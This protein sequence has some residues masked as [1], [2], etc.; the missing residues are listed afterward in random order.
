M[1]P[2]PIFVV[3]NRVFNS[4]SYNLKSST[5]LQ[6]S[7]ELRVR[8]APGKPMNEGSIRYQT[9]RAEAIYEMLPDS[10]YFYNSSG[11][12]YTINSIM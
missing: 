5:R 12:F 3:V 8:P 7:A 2:K 9:F 11:K 10:D 1:Y 6:D 4:L